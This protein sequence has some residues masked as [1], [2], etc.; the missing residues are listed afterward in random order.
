MAKKDEKKETVSKAKTTK[1][2]PHGGGTKYNQMQVSKG[3][4]THDGKPGHSQ[5]KNID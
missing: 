4:M 3:F 1:K 5:K 2:G